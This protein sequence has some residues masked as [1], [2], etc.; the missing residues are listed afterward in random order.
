MQKNLARLDDTLIDK[1]CQPLADWIFESMTFDCFQI[2]R[3]CIDLS[4]LAWIVSQADGAVV[5]AKTGTSGLMAFQF[6]LIVLGLG[7]IMVL[8][9]VFERGGTAGSGRGARANPLRAPMYIH[10]LVCLLGLNNVLV[11]MVAAPVDL[12]SM[13]LLLVGGFTVT[14]VYMGACSNRPPERRTYGSGDWQPISVRG[15]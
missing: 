2:S 12:G 8:R 9:S 3:F 10:R 6:T 1:V 7:A 13:A 11:Q 14:A 15:R 5:A 4:A